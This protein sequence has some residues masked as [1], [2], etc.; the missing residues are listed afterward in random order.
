MQNRPISKQNAVSRSSVEVE[1]VVNDIV[2]VINKRLVNFVEGSTVSVDMK[3]FESGLSFEVWKK[4]KVRVI[5][6]F[7][8]EGWNIRFNSGS[9]RDE[10]CQFDLS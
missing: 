10:C 1:N 7:K 2:G 3:K 6:L 5:E 9:Q 4:V 8:A